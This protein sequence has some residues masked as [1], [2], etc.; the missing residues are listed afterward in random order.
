MEALEDA[1][2]D[3]DHAA[4]EAALQLADV[5]ALTEA[6]VPCVGVS[7][8]SG[9]R[10]PFLPW[11]EGEA[12]AGDAVRGAAANLL[13]VTDDAA[14][15]GPLTLLQAAALLGEEDM[16]M[17]LLRRHVRDGGETRDAPLT[18]VWGAAGNTVLHTAAFCG[19]NRLV[20]ALLDAGASPLRRNARGHRAV[21]CADNPIT[22]A[23][24]N[25]A[26]G[27]STSASRDEE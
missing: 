24:F 12:E 18:Q 4:F 1:L 14:S 11:E 2:R 8:R 27:M 21:D 7:R 20:R 22:C 25:T 17:A 10:V 13:G 16:A 23:L 9:T 6:R 5:H 19:E 26:A 3:G 15:V